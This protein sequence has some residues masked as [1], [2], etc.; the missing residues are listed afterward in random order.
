[1]ATALSQAGLDFARLSKPHVTLGR[2]KK[3]IRGLNGVK[4]FKSSGEFAVK[5]V[6][7]ME[8]RLRPSGSVYTPLLRIPLK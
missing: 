6:A 8:S 2:F 4:Y 5:E 3:G 7:I 1:L